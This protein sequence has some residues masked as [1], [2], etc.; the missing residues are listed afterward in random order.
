MLTYGP[1]LAAWPP[2]LIGA[3]PVDVKDDVTPAGAKAEGT[4]G[5]V[6]GNMD[7]GTTAP[8]ALPAWVGWYEPSMSSRLSA[9][10]AA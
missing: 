2:L 6:E 8:D 1:A 5:H 9:A 10:S 3:Q 7:E 4:K